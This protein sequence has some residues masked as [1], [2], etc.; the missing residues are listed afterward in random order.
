MEYNNECFNK[1][2]KFIED[3]PN[4]WQSL[5]KQKP[6]SLKS[7]K[8][9]FYNPNWYM[10][11]YNLFESKLTDPIVKACRGSV[12]DISNPKD[13]KIICAPYLK[14]CNLGEFPEED[15][16]ID[17][18]TAWISEKIDGILI[19]AAK[20][21]GKFYWFT[22]GS[23]DLNAPLM[24][25]SDK[26]SEPE[27]DDCQ[28]FFDLLYYALKKIEN[29]E[30]ETIY[31]IEED[32]KALTTF[33]GWCDNFEDG[34]TLCLELV[35][36][37]NKIICDYP[38]TKLWLHGYRDKDMIEK[39][40]ID[41]VNEKLT[42]DVPR[43][44]DLNHP[45]AEAVKAITNSFDG[46]EEE[47]VVICDKNWHRAKIKSDSYL[48]LKFMRGVNEISDKDIFT[49][50]MLD[51]I[52]DMIT[53]GNRSRIENIKE[54]INLFLSQYELFAVRF[55]KIYD[56][57][58]HNNRK[59]FAVNADKLGM[60]KLRHIVFKI[61]DGLSAKVYMKKAYNSSN[62][63]KKFVDDLHNLMDYNGFKQN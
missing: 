10:L 58:C 40:A 39:K 13:V 31:N 50:I 46:S 16:K 41:V 44:F 36:P 37:K 30:Y 4:D 60:S 38:E 9:S 63:Y 18:E 23:F 49:Y 27:T 51:E 56:E 12:I 62:S 8:Q 21:N 32:A 1:L 59:E 15:K 33:G 34:T 7:I 11:V 22:N 43:I 57:M 28:T 42:I 48:Q 54:K 61:L 2:V 53:D 35:S 26:Y 5:L 3:N 20:Y 55:V 24:A 45:T 29:C 14:F 17:W 47:G 52:D 6:Y 25:Y 19:K